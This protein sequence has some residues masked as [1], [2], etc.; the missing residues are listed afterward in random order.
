MKRGDL[1]CL[2]DPTGNDPDG[3][4]AIFVCFAS[5]LAGAAGHA[6]AA[7]LDLACFRRF[8]SHGKRTRVFLFGSRWSQI[9]KYIYSLRS[10]STKCSRPRLAVRRLRKGRLTALRPSHKHAAETIQL[11]GQQNA[12]SDEVAFC[13]PTCV[14]KYLPLREPTSAREA[15][16]SVLRTRR[17]RG[18]FV[19]LRTLDAGGGA[20]RYSLIARPQSMKYPYFLI[21]RWRGLGRSRQKIERIF[22]WF[23][24]ASSS[25]K[26]L[27]YS[28]HLLESLPLRFF[29][30]SRRA[31]LASRIQR[32]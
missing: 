14:M 29:P 7:S 22:L 2:C 11:L 17:A 19:L 3:H 15:S 5:N 25:S 4:Q 18:G 12:T 16:D 8:D 9:T 6:S 20:P 10:K 1:F 31:G 21:F 27:R 24:V 26:K 32:A 23:G 28:L 13:C 30:S